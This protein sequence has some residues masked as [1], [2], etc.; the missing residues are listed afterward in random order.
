MLTISHPIASPDSL[1]TL[2]LLCSRSQELPNAAPV[3]ESGLV[4]QSGAPPSAAVGDAPL[5]TALTELLAS[6]IS[7]LRSAIARLA[8][9]SAPVESEV[10]SE[11][12]PVVDELPGEAPADSVEDSVIGSGGAETAD[13]VAYGLINPRKLDGFLWK[14]VSDSDGKLVILL[15]TTMKGRVRSVRILS[16]NGAE[17]IARGRSTGYA[18]GDRQHFRF[19]KKGAH[20]PDGALVSIVGFGGTERRLKIPDTGRRIEGR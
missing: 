13:P 12:F 8:Q 11:L 3:T 18:N 6:L 14:P 19:T 17:V 20:F 9:P 16:P 4:Q 1:G 10:N 5:L 7:L 2:R 15:P